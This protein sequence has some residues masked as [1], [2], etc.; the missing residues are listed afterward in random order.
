MITDKLFC[1]RDW[2]NWITRFFVKW[3]STVW[4]L[5]HS[6][7]ELNFT[8]QTGRECSKIFPAI[9]GRESVYKWF[10]KFDQSTFIPELFFWH[11]SFSNEKWFRT[12]L[13][14]EHIQIWNVIVFFCFCFCFYSLWSRS[15]PKNNFEITLLKYSKNN[16]ERIENFVTLN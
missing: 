9:R 7:R 13:M 4:Y 10:P 11:F 12:L 1:M 6:I 8:P 3:N 2:R 15:S 5:F 16:V 14:I